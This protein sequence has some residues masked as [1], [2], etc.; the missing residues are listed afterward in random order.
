MDIKCRY[1]GLMPDCVVIVATV[2]ALK[3]HSGAV[4]GGAPASRWTRS[5][6][7]GEPAGCR[8]RL[9]PTWSSRSRT[10]GC[11][12]CRWSSRSTASPTT[13][14][15]EIELIRQ[16]GASQA[17]AEGACVSEV[18]AKGG[19]GGE[20]LAEAVVAA[21]R[22]AEQLPVPLPADV[23]I[24]EKIETIATQ[25]LRRRRRGLPARCRAEDQAV[26][27]AGLRQAADLHGQDPPLAVARPTLKGRPTGFAVPIRD[28]RASLGAGFLYPLLG[29]MRRCPACRQ[30]RRARRSTSTR[31]QG[32]R[33]V[34]TAATLAATSLAGGPGR[35]SC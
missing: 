16:H 22:E 23:P 12:A 24:K 30:S 14:T 35:P 1:S 33:P 2:R 21:A 5:L 11:S 19:A 27:R 17:G 13:P 15:E 18:W 9:R 32:R 31:R 3:M 8:G 4:Q 25:D 28:I 20:E 29:K 6:T 34:L 26:H 7:Q 10:C